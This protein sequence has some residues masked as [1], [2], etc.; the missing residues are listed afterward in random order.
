MK[1]Y[2]IATTL[3]ILLCLIISSFILEVHALGLGSPEQYIQ[4]G[5]DGDNGAVVNIGNTIVG[6]VRAVGSAI[7]ILMLTIL[8]VKYL[9]ASVAEKA[10]YKQTMLPYV[11][12]AIL[13]FAGSNVTSI[14]YNIFNE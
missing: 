11:I 10:E 6:V 4:Q 9:M 13:I 3:I 7:S 14:I 5:G 2:I 8:G 1:K 12:G